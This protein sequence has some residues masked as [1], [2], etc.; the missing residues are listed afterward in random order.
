MPRP[1][2]KTP[3]GFLEGF[4]VRLPANMAQWI[5][6]EAVMHK[7]SINAAIYQHIDD[8]RNFFG[9]PKEVADL[10]RRD[11]AVIGIE[12]THNYMKCLVWRE[13]KESLTTSKS[14]KEVE[15]VLKRLSE[16]DARGKF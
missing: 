9:L 3:P 10:L 13:Y 8:S 11:M 6:D 7:C 4:S 1:I 15:E 2:Y 12:S 14:K 5:R 16:M